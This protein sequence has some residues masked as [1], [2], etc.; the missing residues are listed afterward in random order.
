MLP[1]KYK[2]TKMERGIVDYIV[3]QTLK[4]IREKRLKLGYSQE[5]MADKIGISQ[6]A[7][8]KLESG[9]TDLTFKVLLEIIKILQIC[10]GKFLKKISRLV[11][12]V[13]KKA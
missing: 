11:F 5:Y 1:V 7:Y 6:G 8:S 13:K 9:K 12:K 10:E 2:F 4:A 3:T